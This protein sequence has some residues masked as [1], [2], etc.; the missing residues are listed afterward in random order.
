MNDPKLLS[1]PSTCTVDVRV[2][3]EVTGDSNTKEVCRVHN[4]NNTIVNSNIHYWMGFVTRE[5]NYLGFGDVET[6]ASRSNPVGNLVN[7]LLQSV[8][9]AGGENWSIQNDIICVENQGGALREQN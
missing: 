6:E 8:Y 4:R 5:H 7:I 2:P 9:V 3:F 1:G